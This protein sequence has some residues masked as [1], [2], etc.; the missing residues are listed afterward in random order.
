VARQKADTV[1]VVVKLQRE[2][3]D[4]LRA[5]VARDGLNQSVFVQNAVV[6]AIRNYRSPMEFIAE[7]REKADRG[8]VGAML[9]EEL[10]QPNGIPMVLADQWPGWSELW[11]L[12][13]DAMKI[14]DEMRSELGRGP[15]TDGE[16]KAILKHMGSEPGWKRSGNG[17]KTISELTPQEY[18]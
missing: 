15:L 13:K 6:R 3:A 9:N 16:K 12:D 18:Q 1:P 10:D 7:G 8:T 11:A 2:L 5:I 14:I 4:T 17:A